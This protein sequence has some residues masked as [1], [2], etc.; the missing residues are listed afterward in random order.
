MEDVQFDEGDTSSSYRTHISNS[1]KSKLARTLESFVITC[2]ISEKY[3]MYVVVSILIV[4]VCASFFMLYTS[5]VVSPA[6][7]KTLPLNYTF[8]H[9]K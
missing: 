3:A 1:Q 4:I 6:K 8:Y 2:G 9:N 5:T 7:P